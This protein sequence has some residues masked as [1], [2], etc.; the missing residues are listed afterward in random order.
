MNEPI[1]CNVASGKNI[2][3]TGDKINLSIFGAAPATTAVVATEAYNG[4]S[5]KIDEE[6]E[7]RATCHKEVEKVAG[8][9]EIKTIEKK[10]KEE[11]GKKIGAYGKHFLYTPFSTN[12]T[13]ILIQLVSLNSDPYQFSNLLPNNKINQLNLFLYLLSKSEK[14][15]INYENFA[16]K[17]IKIFFVKSKDQLVDFLLKTIG[18]EDLK[19]IVQ[20][21][22][23]DP[24]T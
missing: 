20:V 12:L 18:F 16:E 21:R 7:I 19:I 14:L 23:S 15:K 10:E 24:E 5:F 2:R 22:F 8:N 9:K 11:V 17:I 1:Q 4:S 6:S 13:H 3:D